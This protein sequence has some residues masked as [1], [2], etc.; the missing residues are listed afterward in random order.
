ME[1]ER[2]RVRGGRYVGRDKREI[3]GGNATGSDRGRGKKRQREGERETEGE[4]MGGGGR[5]R[6]ATQEVVFLSSGSTS[7]TLFPV[8]L[9][10]P[11]DIPCY[12]VV[13]GDKDREASSMQHQTFSLS[14]WR[15]PMTSVVVVCFSSNLSAVLCPD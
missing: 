13:G 3:K 6:E 9:V 1:G 12:P 7:T 8:S 14:V 11:R 2:V 4:M 5:G 10:F 15:L